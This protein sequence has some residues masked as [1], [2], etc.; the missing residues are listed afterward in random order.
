L[1]HR[2]CGSFYI[3]KRIDSARND[4]RQVEE[5]TLGDPL[6]LAKDAFAE[7]KNPAASFER[8]TLLCI[9]RVAGRQN[10]IPAY[11]FVYNK[12]E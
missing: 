4:A 5:K 6:K 11:L 3:L 8:R 10:W 2:V 7:E 1:E 12:A 9:T